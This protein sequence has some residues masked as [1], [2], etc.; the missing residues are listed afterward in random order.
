MAAKFDAMFE[1]ASSF[2]CCQSVDAPCAPVKPTSQPACVGLEKSSRT[3]TGLTSVTN[4]WVPFGGKSD[5]FHVL[6]VSASQTVVSII[7]DTPKPTPCSA[8]VVFSPRE[9]GAAEMSCVATEP[10]AKSIS[11]CIEE[12]RK[13]PK[14]SSPQIPAINSFLPIVADPKGTLRKQF[15]FETMSSS[16]YGE[17]ARH[18]E[19]PVESPMFDLEHESDEGTFVEQQWKLGNISP[20]YVGIDIVRDEQPKLCVQDLLQ[21]I[22]SL[23]DLASMDPEDCRSMLLKGNSRDR[24]A[25][26]E[27]QPQL[28]RLFQ[29]VHRMQ[30]MIRNLNIENDAQTADLL[31]VHAE[32]RTKDE[33]LVQMETVLTKLQE[34]NHRLTQRSKSVRNRARKLLQQFQDLVN[35]RNQNNHELLAIQLQHHE[36][37]LRERRVSNFSEMDDHPDSLPDGESLLSTDDSLSTATPSVY[38]DGIATLRISRV[39][40]STWPPLELSSE[41]TEL[42]PTNAGQPGFSIQ[43]PLPDERS[44]LLPVFSAE[45]C[46]R[47]R[48]Q[49]QSS[50]FATSLGPRPVQSYTLQL[51]RP[52]ELQFVSLSATASAAETGNTFAVCAYFGFDATLNIKPTL[53][54][55]LLQINKMDLN[56]DWTVL[57]LEQHIRDLGPRA[58]MTF[59]NDNWSKDQQEV[60]QIAIQE[61][62]SLHR[63][64]GQ[65]FSATVF[66]NPFARNRSRS[67]PFVRKE[68]LRG[69]NVL[70]ILKLSGKTETMLNDVEPEKPKSL[71]AYDLGSCEASSK[72]SGSNAEAENEHG[73]EVSA[74]MQIAQPSASEDFSFSDRDRTTRESNETPNRANNSCPNIEFETAMLDRPSHIAHTENPVDT[75]G[76]MIISSMRHVGKLFQFGNK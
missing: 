74:S 24:F 46:D 48:Q 20:T 75:A 37:V 53:G 40:T 8:T 17:M 54:A 67:E 27:N 12:E 6:S 35:S 4:G 28:S 66:V 3:P 31:Q 10:Q 16:V 13:R 49:Y 25:I 72:T 42:L 43:K 64:S 39:R 59:R 2:H 61:K 68:S 47:H 32:M 38:D 58:T 44:D 69:K 71:E 50:P 60:L 65:K 5:I 19:E 23:N 9:V 15:P 36:Q 22:E 63:G 30:S 33:R 29:N 7:L 62:E 11:G 34:R 45:Q 73:K 55:R 26:V 21:A 70:S 14:P 57:D 56:P 52:F 18:V 1:T 76:E 51:L 41:S